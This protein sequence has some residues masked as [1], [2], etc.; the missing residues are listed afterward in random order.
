MHQALLTSADEKNAV[1]QG[2][3]EGPFLLE[4]VAPLGGPNKVD[5]IPGGQ[6][7]EEAR[8]RGSHRGEKAGGGVICWA[9]LAAGGHGQQEGLPRDK[10]CCQ[11]PVWMAVLYSRHGEL[12]V[13][14]RDGRGG[15]D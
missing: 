8:A 4:D 3:A 10:D 2:G 1:G 9:H 11:D 7:R 12:V 15:G 13:W 6:P 14:G 5:G